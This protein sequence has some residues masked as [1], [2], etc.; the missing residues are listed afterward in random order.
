M[1]H[2]TRF[3]FIV[4]VLLA[5]LIG[6]THP[7]YASEIIEDGKIESGETINDDVFLSGDHVV[8][9]GTVNGLLFAA[10][11]TV[12]IHGTVNGD[13]LAFG[14][15]VTLAPGA[16][17]EG[18]IFL[19]A[20]TASIEGEVLG[21]LFGGSA[22]LL[23][24]EGAAIGRNLY[25]GGY[26][27]EAAAGSSIAQDAFIGGYQALLHGEAGRDV[28]I[29]AG[30]LELT[31]SVGR[32]LTAE[33]GSAT[34]VY[35][36]FFFDQEDLP[37]AVEPGLRIS[38][39][40]TIGGKLVY[41]SEVDQQET[42]QAEPAGGMVYQTPVPE[43]NENAATPSDSIRVRYP[44]LGWMISFIRD[45]VTLLA[46]GA[47]AL[48][49]IPSALQYTA[50]QARIQ[51]GQSAGY[52]LLAIF[53]GYFSGLVALVVILLLGIL[54][55]LLSLGGLIAPV[56]GI[57]FSA[58][59][60]ILA[61]FSFLISTGSKLV[62]AYLVGLLLIERAAPQVQNRPLWAMISGIAIYVLISFIPLVGFLIAIAATLI[63]MGAMWLAYQSWR[64]PSAV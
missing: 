60:F 52:G 43:E 41:T 33:V 64:K 10:G 29:G 30:A 27:I 13:V 12:T 15:S 9:D 25:Y 2:W 28:F 40:A 22:S 59:A 1:K 56:Y 54:L 8:M 45:L 62:V 48:W 58:L 31:G 38:E 18:N 7:V 63:G 50:N 17:V 3:G 53:S 32:N 11:E 26:N 49:L 39:N 55:G 19:G 24:G 34:N 4:A 61:I 42:I 5:L 20:R 35:R 21:S 57:G 23:L 14:N 37:D 51:P 46:F 44:A 36:P 16:K 47:L 6:S